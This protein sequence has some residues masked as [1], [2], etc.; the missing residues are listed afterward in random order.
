MDPHFHGV[1]FKLSPFEVARRLAY[2]FPLYAVLD[3]REIQPFVEGHIPGAIPD[4]R[5]LPAAGE[6]LVV[7]E[8]DTD[9][10]VRSASR[11]LLA[12]G[13]R[14]TEVAGGMRAWRVNKLPL[15]KGAF[16]APT[17]LSADTAKG[18]DIVF[19]DVDTQVDFM[20]P[21][22]KLY[23]PEA[24][25]LTDNLA[26]LTRLADEH[27]IAVV[28][29]ADDHQESDEEISDR[30]DFSATYPPHCMRGTEGAARVPA[31]DR[32]WTA[33]LGHQPLPVAAIAA[34]ADQAHPRVLVHKKR[35]DVFSNPNTEPLVAALAP[36]HIVLYGVAL[37]VCNKAAVEGLLERG[38]TNLTVVTDATK[39]IRAEAAEDLL[40]SWRKRG[41]TL[42][43]TAEVARQITGETEEEE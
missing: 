35:F 24:E 28:G 31:T 4:P 11:E 21:D 7:G 27:G 42:A 6:V 20:D 26:T 15:R 19:W 13:R 29:S 36:E 25:T 2:D 32:T 38:Y 10:R 16:T 37:D 33:E 39:P 43:T 40:A 17:E 1:V 3:V 5:H 14:V 8:D 34:I 23:V 30:P 12:A 22:G 41:A 9:A 18:H